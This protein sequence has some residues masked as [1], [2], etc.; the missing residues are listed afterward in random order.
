MT[1]KDISNIRLSSQK[2]SA[3][4]FTTPKEIVAWMGALQ[5][6]DYAMAKWAVGLR[7]LNPTIEKIEK[8]FDNGDIIRTDDNRLSH[9][10]LCA[11]LDCLV[12]SGPIKNNKQTYT[13]LQERVPHMNVLTREESL[14]E[15]AKRYFTSH[16]PATLKDFLWWSGLSS[17]DAKKALEY[18]RS[19]FISET[20]GSEKYWMINSFPKTNN[21]KTSIY[22]LPAY[23]EFLISYKDRSASLSMPDFK[24]AVLSNGIFRPVILQNGQ[25]IGLWKR[26]IQ[27]N[28][29]IL[30]PEFF[31]PPDKV[32]RSLLE[33]KVYRFGQFLNKETEIKANW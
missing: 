12:C 29:V 6:Q 18:V 22:L 25:V 8:S 4:E 31:Q 23:D 26:F 9:I 20:I 33:K 11:E 13:L 30:E 16:S 17:I 3:S 5:A 24:K 10:M 7:L 19:G 1:F 14:A 27:G 15:L 32:T 21:N 28:S 2:I